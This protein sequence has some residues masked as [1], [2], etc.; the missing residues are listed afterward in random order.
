MK[1]YQNNNN[2]NNNNNN[3]YIKKINNDN[4]CNYRCCRMI[5]NTLDMIII[6]KQVYIDKTSELLKL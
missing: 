6:T 1:D 4:T 5:T 2:N 3:K